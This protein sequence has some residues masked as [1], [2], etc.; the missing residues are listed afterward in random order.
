MIRK[1]FHPQ[2]PLIL[3]SSSSSSLFPAPVHSSKPSQHSRL[4]GFQFVGSY[5]NQTLILKE[6]IHISLCIFT[7][8]EEI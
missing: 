4:L 6:N 5:P 8:E 3:S 2:S 1:I 7:E